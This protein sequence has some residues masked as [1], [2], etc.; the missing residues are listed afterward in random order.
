MSNPNI[1]KPLEKLSKYEKEL[2]LAKNSA[3]TSKIFNILLNLGKLCYDIEAYE[4]GLNYILEAIE[5]SKKSSDFPTSYEFY[6][7]LGDFNF[8]QGLLNEAYEAYNRSNK[9]LP[10]KE[11]FKLR[12]ENNFRLGK[13]G[14]LLDKKSEAIKHFKEAEKI[15]EK[16]GL[17]TERARIYNRIGLVYLKKI[18]VDITSGIDKIGTYDWVGDSRFTKARKNFKRAIMILEQH[19][20]LE[21]ES[22]LYNT[23]KANLE[24]KF[25][26][27]WSYR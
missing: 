25:S 6:K 27:Y 17:H 4:L 18:N 12:A 15:F 10:K 9:E 11:F 21:A 16:L 2:E 8:E 1:E 22:E 20:L 24:A 14:E 23:I 19:N 26:D 7:L 3:D 5:L 13:V